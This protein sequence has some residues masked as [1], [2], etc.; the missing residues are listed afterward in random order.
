MCLLSYHTNHNGELHEQ[1]VTRCKS[2]ACVDRTPHQVSCP[3][4]G[5]LKLASR[6]S[7]PS[8]T[9][10]LMRCPGGRLLTTKAVGVLAA[11][12]CCDSL[13][14]TRMSS[15]EAPP[16]VEDSAELSF[17]QRTDTSTEVSCAVS[18]SILASDPVT[19]PTIGPTRNADSVPNFHERLL[20]LRL[21]LPLALAVCSGC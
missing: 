8:V 17:S 13:K 15:C 5:V 16:L 3:G 7:E 1:R 6:V 20:A 4:A 14:E 10:T 9:D 11:T 21:P 2:N 19:R 18:M 12:F